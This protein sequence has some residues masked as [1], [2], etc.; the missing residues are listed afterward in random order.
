MTNQTYRQIYLWGDKRASSLDSH[1]LEFLEQ[2]F[3]TNRK[4]QR[5]I[6]DAIRAEVPLNIPPGKLDQKHQQFFQQLLGE[7]NMQTD[8]YSRATHA[9]GKFYGDL[10]N[11]KQQTVPY[12]PDAVLYPETHRHVQQIIEYCH[13]H[14]VP[15]VPF[16]GGSSVTRALEARQGGVCVDLSKHL[17]QVLHFSQ[18]NH[19]VRVQA[20]IMGPKLEEYLNARGFTCGHFPQSFEFSTVGGWIAARGAGQCSTGYG[21]AEDLMQAIQVATPIGTYNSR[22]YPACAQ[23]WDLNRLFAGSEGVLGVITEVTWRVFQLRPEN[24]QRNS[25]VFRDFPTAAHA[26][27]EMIQSEIGKPHLFRISDGQETLFGFKH[28]GFEGTWKDRLLRWLG[29]HPPDRSTMLVMVE[30]DLASARCTAKRVKSIAKRHGGLVAGKSPIDKWLKQRFESSY[31]RDAFMDAGYMIDTMETA[32]TWDRLIPLWTALH[33]LFESHRGKLYGMSHISHVYETGC[34]LYAIFFGPMKGL[35]AKQEL[36]EFLELQRSIIAT[37]VENGGSISHH[38]GVG[39]MG[40]D[41][42]H[43]QFDPT[44]LKMLRGIKHCLDPH[45]IMNPGGTLGL[46]C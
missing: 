7:R 38:H 33:Q 44:G 18:E 4:R 39:R 10:L 5:D 35:P 23:G 45:A 9:L 43:T 37:F 17:N 11:L 28:Q 15:V 29:Y 25:F 27:R 22:D 30:G 21:R 41:F 26:M 20:G 40:M 19:T 32:V 13:E 46:D 16:G 34:N 24:R 3:G 42:M 8:G 12:P 36:S 2:Y 6:A 14:C 31:L 1:T